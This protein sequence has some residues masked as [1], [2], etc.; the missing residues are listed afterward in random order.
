MAVGSTS[1]GTRAPVALPAPMNFSRGLAGETGQRRTPLDRLSFNRHNPS[2]T[3]Q[4][5][6][7]RHIWP[8]LV[9]GL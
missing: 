1:S 4:S 2:L 9:I 8:I 3:C 6:P 5:P 7:C